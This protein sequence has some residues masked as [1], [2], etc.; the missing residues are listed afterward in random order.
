M[1]NRFQRVLNMNQTLYIKDGDFWIE[2]CDQIKK[3]LDENTQ[4]GSK[5]ICRG[6]ALQFKNAYELSWFIVR[7]A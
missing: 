5:S 4:D 6:W 2:N 1:S 7:W 3:W